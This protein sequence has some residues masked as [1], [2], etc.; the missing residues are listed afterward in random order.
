MRTRNKTMAIV[1]AALFL[2]IFLATPATVA[3]AE[4]TVN[5]GT[6]ASFAVLA[7]TTVTNTGTTDISG[8][9]G[10]DVGVWPGLAVTGLLPADLPDGV[11]HAGDAVAQQ[12]QSDLTTAYNDAA[13]RSVTENL[14]GDDLGGMT[15]TTGVYKFDSTAQLTGN[16]T[17]DA[18]G[19]PDAA[20]IFQ[21]GSTL[22][23]A[24]ASSFELINGAQFC[25][26][27]WQIGS[28]AT[29]GTDSMFIGH[30]FALT[31]ITATTGAEVQGQLLAR[32]G[33]VTLDSNTITNGVCEG[34]ATPTPTTAATPTPTT[35]ASPTPTTAA[36]PTPTTAAT[37]TPTTAA[38]TPTPTTAAATPT[39]QPTATPMPTDNEELPQ[40]GESDNYIVIG[41]ILLGLASTLALYNWRR[42]KR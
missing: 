4:P 28:S 30:I 19:N 13:G 1:L 14:S 16:L 26:V 35:A 12:A 17:L 20:F 27:F 37:P 7:G 6:T 9:A 41:I 8:S 21:I 29:L 31:S 39:T 5:L 11:I 2:V 24:S 10:G 3:A 42:Q 32:N 40:T 25:R 15:L 23:T 36:T 38:A 18:E 33:A 34:D 22:T